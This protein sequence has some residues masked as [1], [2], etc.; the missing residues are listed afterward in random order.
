M[1]RSNKLVVILPLILTVFMF[2]SGMYYLNQ[3]ETI[4]NE[5]L[6]ESISWTPQLT[7]E[8]SSSL[9]EAEWAWQSSPD[10][11]I[12]GTDYIGVTF[13]DQN[14][15]TLTGNEFK[16]ATVSLLHNGEI[17]WEELGEI[18]ESG[19][20]FTFPNRADDHETYGNDGSIEVILTGT[21]AEEAVV[22]YLHTWKE[23]EEMTTE[24]LRF[25]DPSFGESDNMDNFYWV[26]EQFV[27][28]EEAS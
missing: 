25:F 22:T 7:E 27:Q 21:K 8:D 17:I 6:S 16:E 3:T 12:I 10:D 28:V 9:L 18:K 11:G 4:T 19:V 20:L 26:T 13:L 24:D 15:E 14:G 1:F 5:E 23:H 2:A